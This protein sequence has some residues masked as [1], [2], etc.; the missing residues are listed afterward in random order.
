MAAREI[1][2][3]DSGSVSRDVPELSVHSDEEERLLSECQVH[4]CLEVV[5]DCV[6][7]TLLLTAPENELAPRSPLP[8]RIPS[9]SSDTE[10]PALSAF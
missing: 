6:E 1:A 3:S 10:R 9:V 2:L 8:G 7:S 4:G 5:L